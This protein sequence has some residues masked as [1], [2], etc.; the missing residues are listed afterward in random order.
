ME[1]AELN[2]FGVEA[3]GVGAVFFS[4]E[5]DGHL[6]LVVSVD[7]SVIVAVD[8]HV[9]LAAVAEAHAAEVVALAKAHAGLAE[10]LVALQEVHV[11]HT[12]LAISRCRFFGSEL[13]H[14]CSAVVD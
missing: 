4:L 13:N 2:V 6:A 7:H 1:V 5:A 14:T 11:D 12:S 9:D 8:G 3:E 10:V